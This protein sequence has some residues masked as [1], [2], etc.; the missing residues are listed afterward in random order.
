MEDLTYARADESTD[1]RVLP[2]AS[3]PRPAACDAWI[4]VLVDCPGAQ[5]LFT[6]RAATDVRPGDIVSVPFGAQQ[7]G[8]IAVRQLDRLPEGLKP[9]RVKTIEDIVVSGFFSPTYWR[10]LQ[11]VADYYRAPL[12]Q[13]IKVALPPGLLGRSQRRVRLVPEAV[14]PGASH[15]LSPAGDRL[16]Q[17]L[18]K[19]QKTNKNHSYT[20]QYLQRQV[21]DSRR[22]L[23]ELIE[24][25]WAQSY[26]EA[27]R[28]A[29]PKQRLAV[30]LLGNAVP[31]SLTAKQSG[32]LQTLRRGGGE[33]WLTELLQTA[34]CNSS[35]VKAL[36]K[37]GCVVIR[38]REMLRGNN[39]DSSATV[40]EVGP[41]ENRPPELTPDQSRALEAI[42]KI[43]GFARVLLHGVTGSGKTEVYLRAIAP[44]L[45]AG[46][47][48]L[49]LVPEIGLTP[50]LAD[51]FRARF[52]NRASV[53][54]SALSEGERYDA[55]RQMLAGEPQVIIGTRSAVFVP[56]PNLG[57]IVLDEEYDSSFKQDRPAPTYHA[58]TVAA[59]RA[60]L[61]GC[62]LILGAAT[63]ALET[64]AAFCDRAEELNGGDRAEELNGGDRAEE[65]NGGDRAEELNSG[66]HA[67][68]LN[69]GDR[70]YLSLPQ[71][72]EARP[73]PPVTIAD[74]R[75]ELRNGNRSI[76]S[77]CLQDAL[78]SLQES[79]RQGI[80]FIPR[81]GHSTFVSCRSCG[82][83]VECPHC[84]VS[85]SYHHV[86]ASA[87]PFLR[88]HYCNYQQSQ[89]N[90]CP[91]CG[92]PY[93]KHFGTGTQRVAQE[94]S[95]QFP[96]LPFLRFDSDTTRAKGAH[97]ALLSR[98]AAGE[99][100]LLV[101]T[102]MLT[103]GLD[104]PQVTLVGVLAA[105]GLLN[106]PDFRASERAFQAIAQVA[107]RAGRGS[108]PGR[109]IVQTYTPDHPT[110][111]AVRHHDYAAFV[112]QELEDR[113]IAGYPPY[114]RLVLFRLSGTREL[115]VETT[116]IEI[117]RRLQPWADAAGADLLGPAPAAIVRVERHFRWQILLKL[118][119]D[120]PFD[121]DVVPLQEGCRSRAIALTVD[122]DPLNLT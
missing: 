48:A 95:R 103:K 93:F 57:A 68:E 59:W 31:E 7:V 98:F 62:P 35:V 87:N 38:E 118:P 82:Y 9:E 77:R 88:C 12:M 19:A 112:R 91:A 13:T 46:K 8:A 86:E 42:Q 110:I 33:M 32:A 67:E 6:Y 78:R 101:G 43:D 52:G 39:N 81:R 40:G 60:E 80:L 76:F 34:A 113:A 47:S 79:D 117:A 25:G 99:A 69:S 121:F 71:R 16:L 119:L 41:Q 92:S 54:H 102:Q 104:L 26:L 24:R 4:E 37:K 22:G 70:L 109:A 114:K 73:L 94:I 5:G 72:I 85:L 36:E 30:V 10:L 108:E 90:R 29:R 106:L 115:E 55:W 65:L 107:G 89:P 66:G 45:Q 27:P 75:A 105:D 18:Q 23:Q 84:D 14:P 96:Q 11:R 63:P 28:Y 56:L 64:W 50:Q 21:P 2:I 61:E 20:W 83:V 44:L 58:R 17:L 116:A 97:R 100:K 74:M 53:Y 15:F 111:R 1:A 49:V 122:V 3:E 120:R 51:R